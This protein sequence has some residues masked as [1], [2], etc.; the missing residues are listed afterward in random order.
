MFKRISIFL[1]VLL[2]VLC[3]ITVANA[4]DPGLFVVKDADNTYIDYVD[5]DGTSIMKIDD[6]DGVT[7]ASYTAANTYTTMT[8]TSTLDASSLTAGSFVTPGGIACAKQLYLGDD[9]DM[10]VSGTGTYE[11]TLKD[12]VADALSIVGGSTD[13]IVFCTD[14]DAI[15]ITPPTTITGLVTLNGG[16]KL[17]A[18]GAGKDVTFYGDTSGA[19]FVWDQDGDTNGSLTLGSSGGS[20]GVDFVVYGATNGNYLHW[21]RSADDLLLVGTATQLAIAGTTDSTSSTSGSLRT[22][23][24]LGVAKNTYLGGTLTVSTDGGGK[25]VKVYGNTSGYYLLFDADGDTNGAFY[26]G[27]DTKGI[28]T[29]LYGD[30][31]GCGVF[32]NP[33]TDTNGTLSIGASGGSKG[34]DC[35]MYGTTNGKYWKWD[36]SADTVTTTGG[37]IIAPIAAGTFIDFQLETEWVSG[38]LIDADF[39]SATT[40]N[41]D[42]VG[43]ELDFNGNITMTTDKDVTGF[44]V[45]LPA[46]T[47]TAA[48]TTNIKAFDLSTAGA[49]VQNT[50]AG[51]INWTGINIQLPNTTQ[52][53]GTVNSYG[54]YITAGTVTSGSQYGIYFP[55]GTLTTAIA[56]AG[57]CTD[58]IVFSGTV[59][60]E[61]IQIGGTYDHGIRFTEDMVAGDVTNSFINIGDYT[62]GIAVAPSGANMFGVVHNVTVSVDAAYWYQAYY[63]KITTS[64]TT[65][66]TSIAGHALRMNVATNIEAAYGIQCHL[67]MTAGADVTQEAVAVSAYVD[68]G[69]GD[70][71]TDRV[72]A[73]QAMISGSGTAGTVTGLM[74]VAYIANRGTVIDTDA[75]VF[76]NNGTASA[77]DAAVEFDLDGTVTS[78]WEFNG[79][80][81]DGWTSGD[82]TGA[83]WDAQ[84]EYV[85]IPVKVEGIT[86]TLYILAAETYN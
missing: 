58:G 7:I 15:T 62:T 2:T 41:N 11:I 34:V 26:V 86:P 79:T 21:D 74:H 52:T 8:L 46:L 77:S 44:V 23:G 61:A 19:D 82:S 16:L 51:T 55:T 28:L 31:T 66:N 49:L 13:M 3:F 39:G 20:K 84:D 45:K 85:L 59:S 1:I 48:N 70:T 25:D 36:R 69:T 78:C 17:G 32:W 14:T 47:Q 33:S 57:T 6:T 40:L 10:S 65:T 9:I 68:M 12:S 67:N 38:T 60:D 5:A 81:C 50:G 4:T 42:V 18:D 75:I 64:G 54:V 56:L 71:T 43:M 27:A 29:S 76:I 22:A 72:V 83:D 30:T 24:G 63:T 73:L 37:T 35:I 80:V 53:T